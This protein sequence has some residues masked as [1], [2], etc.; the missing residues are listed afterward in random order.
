MEEAHRVTAGDG[1]DLTA[2]ECLHRF[3]NVKFLYL[4]FD[5]WAPN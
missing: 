4:D 3:L 1:V 5:G 2:V